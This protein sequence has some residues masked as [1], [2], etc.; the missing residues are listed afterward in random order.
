MVRVRKQEFD[1]NDQLIVMRQQL[2]AL[3]EI[4]GGR[5][6]VLAAIDKAVTAI[7]AIKGYEKTDNTDIVGE[8][9]SLREAVIRPKNIKFDISRG[10]RGEIVDVVVSI[11]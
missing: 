11:T 8:L 3:S 4:S 2:S 9:K 7:N 10:D 5:E 1:A 6:D